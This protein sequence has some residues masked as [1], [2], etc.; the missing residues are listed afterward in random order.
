MD[1]FILATGELHTVEEFVEAA[2]RTV[3]LAWRN[4]VKFDSELVTTVEPVSPCGN[5]GKARRILG[6]SNSVN[7][8]EMVGRLVESEM[9]KLG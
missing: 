8:E 7:F 6:W 1:D 9:G 2:F 4:Y 5:P 3:G